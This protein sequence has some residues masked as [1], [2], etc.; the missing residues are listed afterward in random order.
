MSHCLGEG[1]ESCAQEGDSKE[2]C[3]SKQLEGWT[4]DVQAT[5]MPVTQ[6]WKYREREI[7]FCSSLKPSDYGEPHGDHYEVT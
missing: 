7:F 4:S 6:A 2:E 1:T 5:A 3:A